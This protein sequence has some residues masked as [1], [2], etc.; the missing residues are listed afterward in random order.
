MHRCSRRQ[1]KNG[2]VSSGFFLVK[3]IILIPRAMWCLEFQHLV[4]LSSCMNS[5]G[6][7]ASSHPNPNGRRC[8]A[9]NFCKK[10][11][12]RHR[13]PH[14]RALCPPQ[15]AKHGT[16][17]QTNQDKTKQTNQPVKVLRSHGTCKKTLVVAQEVRG[18]HCMVQM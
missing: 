16:Q 12:R 4:V 13:L 2:G 17:E 5:G 10:F 3:I 8:R 11:G 18:A 7:A 14:E 6:G 15:G 9:K 1:K